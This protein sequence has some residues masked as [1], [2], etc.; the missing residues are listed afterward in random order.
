MLKLDNAVNI[1]NVYEST[2]YCT[3]IEVFHCEFP[4]NC[5]QIRWKLQIWFTFTKEILNEN[6]IF[7]AVR[8]TLFYARLVSL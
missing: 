4:S 3:K 1:F 5:D 6:F 8:T 2:R 7:C